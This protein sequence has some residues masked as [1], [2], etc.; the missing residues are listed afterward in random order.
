MRAESG[1][2][3]RT[4]W[5]ILYGALVLMPANVY[6]TLVS[7]QSLLGPI[8]FV[9]LI[10][11]VELARLMRAPLRPAEAFIVYAIA[12]VAAGQMTFYTYAVYPAYFRISEYSAQFRWAVPHE[13]W[14]QYAHMAGWNPVDHSV[15]YSSLAPHW[16]APSKAAI[17]KRSF[18]QI[19]WIAPILVGMAVWVF[20]MMADVAMGSIG[21]ELFVKIEKLPF[22]FAHPTAEACLTMTEDK[23]EFRRV[24]ALSGLIGSLWG[25][26]IYWPLAFGMKLIDYP[27]PWWDAHELIGRYRWL[28][29]VS[30]GIATDLLAFTGG[31]IIPR[32]VIVSMFIGSAAIW[33]VGDPI[34][35]QTGLFH[36]RFFPGMRIETMMVQQIY[37]WLPVFIASMVAAALL[38][39]IAQPKALVQA[40]ANLRKTALAARAARTERAAML[41]AEQSA[42]SGPTGLGVAAALGA[43]GVATGAGPADGGAQAA[44]AAARAQLE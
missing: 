2:T 25:L 27:I 24:F 22:P 37:V 36:G 42:A 19:E 5:V 14:A 21:K 44:I 33:L 13:L 7:G 6:L 8:S 32:R 38:H 31:F 41:A 4:W 23:P 15:P 9:A 17:E 20:H 18:F 26:L 12:G 30:F 34:L 3:N 28:D 40:F 35:V 16:W 11:W 43:A 1:L 29:G 39:L 10:L